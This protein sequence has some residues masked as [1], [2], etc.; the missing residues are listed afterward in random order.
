MATNT[1]Y[2]SWGTRKAYGRRYAIDPA[3][4]M[5]QARLENEYALVPGRE[6]R[7][8]SARQFNIQSQR[9]QEQIDKQSRQSA[10]SG[11]TS[12][13][14]NLVGADLMFNKGAGTK[15]L[16]NLATGGSK[17]ATNLGTTTAPTATGPLTSQFPA[18]Q[19]A[20]EL[21]PSITG[22]AE[23]TGTSITQG[24]T[25]PLASQ[26]APFETLP[27]L[28][29]AGSAA[30]AA[31]GTAGAAEG[32][33]GTAGGGAWSSVAGPL[34]IIGA[35]EAVK[36]WGGGM[37][38]G[39]DERNFGEKLMSAPANPF[40][41]TELLGEDNPLSEVSQFFATAEQIAMAPFD[42]LFGIDNA[43][44][45]WICT[46]ID[47]RFILTDKE[48]DSLSKLKR[49]SIKMHRYEAD[50]YYK[51]GHRLTAKINAYTFSRGVYAEAYDTL[52]KKC[53]L[54][55]GE[56]NMEGAYQHYKKITNQLCKDFNVDLSFEDKEVVNG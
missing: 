30:P 12:T 46:E 53:T 6:A 50:Q 38:K 18:F 32:T 3:I 54:L 56:G 47:R 41:L 33:A 10:I 36:G 13:A 25:G 23:A 27:E 49:Y 48:K 14:A 19:A 9:Q 22:T 15:G 51:N 17:V 16:Y 2:T 37:E 55:V 28:A 43:V 35:A 24:T 31:V 45:T 26:Y 7:A 40:A 4:L 8:E 52:V 42:M 20:P 21:A 39:W 34:A 11:I 29:P 44:W 1:G 5:E